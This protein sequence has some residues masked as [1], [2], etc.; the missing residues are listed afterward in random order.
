[1]MDGLARKFDG[2]T[3]NERLF[4]CGL[5]DLWDKSV[6]SKDSAKL[7]VLLQQVGVS[8]AAKVVDQVLSSSM[9]SKT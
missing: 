8:D 9:I 7:M 5:L 2:M 4:S 3:L 1:M 6:R